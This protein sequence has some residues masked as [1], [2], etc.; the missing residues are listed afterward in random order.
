VEVE[1]FEFPP[2]DDGVEPPFVA[3]LNEPQAAAAA[4]VDGPLV[5]FAGAGSGKTRVITYRI[6]NLCAVHSVPPYRILAV[7][8]TNKAA[9]EM[10]HRLEGLIGKDMTRD[11]WVGTFH[12]TSAK[13][14][15]Q[16][17][18]AAGLSRSFVVYDDGDQRAVMNRVV[19]ELR[20]DEKR[21]PPR[22]IL[23]RIHSEKQEGRDA[24]DFIPGNYFDDVVAKCFEAYARHMREASAVDFD[25]LL[26][27]ALKLAESKDRVGE[28][29]RRK[30]R[31]VLVDEFQDVNQVQY[32]LVRA[33]SAQTTNICV[34]GDDDQ[35][36]YRWRGA[37][38]RIVRN[39]K[40]DHPG[41][42]VIKLEQNYRSTK[43]IVDAALGVIRHAQDREPKE[44]WTDN[45]KGQ[46]VRVV[47][48]S[49]ERDEAAFVVGHVREL[50]DRGVSPDEIAVFYR[51]HA[52]S[53][54]LEEV[55]RA[56]RIAYQ[57]VGGV[58][59]FERAEIKNLLSYMRV[60]ANPASDVDLERIINVP[61]RKIGE[62]T[63]S[64]LQAKAGEL[65]ERIGKGVSYFDAIDPLVESRELGAAARK[66]L[67]GFHELIKDLQ[68]FAKTASPSELAAQ[69]LESSGY[70]E[71]LRA[72]ET[73]ESEGRLFNLEE[74]IGSIQEYEEEVAALGDVATLNGYLERVTLSAQIDDMKDVPKVVLMT[75]HG[76]KGLEFSHVMLTGMEEDMFPFRSN[77]PDRKG[78]MEEER[79]LAY[80]A[81]TRARKELIIT[82]TELRN[83]FGSMRLGSPSRFLRD[84]PTNVVE[85]EAT[86]SRRSA[87]GRF[88]DRDRQSWGRDRSES[89]THPMSAGG[90]R[91]DRQESPPPSFQP[92]ERY[93]ER[94]DEAPVRSMPVKGG[95]ALD[96]AALHIGSQVSHSSFGMGVVQ[97]IDE[98]A[99]PTA[100]VRFTGWAPKRVKVRFLKSAD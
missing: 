32:R 18:E 20:I 70:E 67:L 14:L 5:V 51:V 23:S 8:F 82:H 94:D 53:R 71:A 24:A 83:I 100:T 88:I 72:E 59:F 74:F 92:G 76:A 13:L 66:A 63:V 41:S 46:L 2:I 57:I 47:A 48:A 36:I 75:V 28:E 97:S 98:G 38:V 99:D 43:N 6:A 9:G 45:E 81:V 52:Q 77:D 58:R 79:R 62:T 3:E 80:V 55:M 85:N 11:L 69:I 1:D 91:R 15:R 93:V 44:L 4:H 17:H 96:P 54:V 26:L 33:L 50:I 19:K 22:Q 42:E 39:F 7:T 29:L 27:R 90:T 73:D 84:M 10:K 25:D 60:I 35:S 31:Y 56:E 30:F 64:R 34:V 16:Y 87:G 61:A 68:T 12:A 95:R 86:D 65:G 40:H 89:W 21:Y 37:D 49:T 78:D